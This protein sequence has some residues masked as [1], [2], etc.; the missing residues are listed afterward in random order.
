MHNSREYLFLGIL[1]YF[2]FP[3]NSIGKTIAEALKEMD[4]KKLSTND[5]LLKNDVYFRGEKFF[6]KEMND[7]II[8][9]IENR[10]GKSS[11]NVKSGFY[12]VVFKRKD[13]YVISYRGSE[14]S[15]LKEAYR[16][17]IETDL[18]IGLGKR[19]L[20][21]FEGVEVFEGLI[22]E[23]IKLNQ[24]SL[25]GHS[26]GGGIAQFVA[27]MAYKKYMKIPLTYTWNSV[28]IKR[29]GIVN[30]DDFFEYEKI[31]DKCGLTKDEKLIFN[32][33]KESYNNFIIKELKKNKIIRDRKTLLV[34][35]SYDFQF[36][37]TQEFVDSISKQTN[38]KEILKRLPFKR[39]KELFL[40]E[41]FL[42]K[43]FQIEKIVEKIYS[44]IKLQELINEN[45]IFKGKIIN[46]C[47]SKD[48]VSFLF[49]HIGTTYQ[50][51]L[52][53]LKKDTVRV[54]KVLRNFNIFSKSIQDYH[55]EDV[56]I[57]LLDSKGIFSKKVSNDYI[58]SAVRK[59]IYKEVNFNREFLGSYYLNKE[60]SKENYIEQ[61]Q[62]IISGIK[63]TKEN[64]LY[65][66]KILNQIENMKYQ[67][68]VEL[69]N[70]IIKK[71]AS[72]YINQDIYD[73]IIFRENY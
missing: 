39:R 53:F 5:N 32:D 43:F 73:L 64:I 4:L 30:F 38:L 18:L 48:L 22:K 67:E 44:A 72:P 6:S 41:N 59:L 65:K 15:P 31:L 50:V 40:N 12:A 17:F 51:D 57:P 1:A 27:I 2:N 60:L 16:D 13:D 70:K 35:K 42:G 28:G 25:T 26:L 63:K 23:D 58:A 29:D 62:K 55:F 19:P 14:T 21:F 33:F 71:M 68:L 47:H 8:H 45:E 24:I 46:F 3:K 7:W 36:D 37:M 34:D 52:N 10:T 69:W 20:Q 9:K 54:K 11:Q 49:P 56:F 61:K 66:E